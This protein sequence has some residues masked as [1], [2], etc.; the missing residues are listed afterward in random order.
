[1]E[2]T[3]RVQRCLIQQQTNPG[4]RR[5]SKRKSRKSMKAIR[6]VI[7]FSVAA[8]FVMLPSSFM[9]A[10]KKASPIVVTINDV[11]NGAPVIQ[12]QGAPN[13][14]DVYTDP[15][16]ADPAIEDGALITLFGVDRSGSIPD[17]GG[18][19][20]VP[21]APLWYRTAVDIVWVEHDF[22]LFGNGDLQIA[23]DSA[24]AGIYYGTPPDP[25]VPGRDFN[26]G[27]VTDR[28]VTLYEDAILVVQFKPHTDRLRN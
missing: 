20:V 13:G 10:P 16:V 26:A 23:F 7:T 1:M 17:W 25:H 15:N 12:V 18:R 11:P 9:A 22:D 4:A 21:E 28:W 19:F 2:P 24:L 3:P 8:L 5:L 14:Y 27:L 6:Y